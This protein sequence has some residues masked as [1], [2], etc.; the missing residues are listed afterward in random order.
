MHTHCE[1]SEWTYTHAHKHTRAHPTKHLHTLLRVNPEYPCTH[2]FLTHARAHTHSTHAF[3]H[4]LACTHIHL[5]ARRQLTTYWSPNTSTTYIHTYTQLATSAWT[6]LPPSLIPT[7][8]GKF[9]CKCSTLLRTHTPSDIHTHTL[10]HITWNYTY[11]NAH[12][13]TYT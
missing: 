13:Y 8:P 11:T 10:T 9:W 1:A 6:S 3:S 7:F 4:A 2:F 12:T 5:H